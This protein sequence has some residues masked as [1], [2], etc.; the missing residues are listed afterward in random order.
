MDRPAVAV[1]HARSSATDAGIL[2]EVGRPVGDLR[3]ITDFAAAGEALTDAY[4]PHQLHP[5]GHDAALNM[6]LWSSELPGLGLGYVTVDV[7]GD[8]SLT[9][10]PPRP[11]QLFCL[12]ARG[13]VGI[14]LGRDHPPVGGTSAAVLGPSKLMNFQRW[15]PGCRL[16]TAR[17]DSSELQDVLAA[18]LGRPVT[19]P[20][21]FE[22]S[23][24]LA[25]PES[26]PF[27][28]ALRLLRADLR[29]PDA[30]T[31]DPVMAAGLARLLMTG[32]LLAQPHNYS[33]E[34][35]GPA[36]PAAP[37]AIRRAVEFIDSTSAQITTVADVAAAASLSVRALQDGFRRHVGVAPMTYLRDVRLDRVHADLRASDP[38]VT[39]AAAIARRWGFWH[40]G[41]FAAA[42]RTRYGIAPA[43]TLAGAT[44]R[45]R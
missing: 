25:S 27:L 14:A 41:R 39:T 16:V 29:R 11:Y 35:T 42:Y 9:C 34:V 13:H 44:T 17:I 12:A 21:E 30:V 45:Q 4:A 3:R 37:A 38:S 10:R 40:Y 6:G 22:P 8:M 26:A 2:A 5:V 18:M 23:M 20:L 1:P 28:R 43:E 32:L 31:A 33:G 7:D 19:R 36:R 24:D 15:S